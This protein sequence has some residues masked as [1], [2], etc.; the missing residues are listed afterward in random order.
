MALVTFSFG[1]GIRQ[2]WGLKI[3]SK[4]RRTDGSKDKLAFGLV[5]TLKG[6]K[7][8]DRY[9]DFVRECYR[10]WIVNR[11]SIE[12]QID[13]YNQASEEIQFE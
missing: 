5:V 8:I 6:M 7:K 13:V 10:Y 1:I 2:M 3:V 12:N 11:I 9:D 4:D